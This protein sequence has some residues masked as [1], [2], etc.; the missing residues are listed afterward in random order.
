MIDFFLFFLFFCD[1]YNL[2]ITFLL[3]SIFSSAWKLIFNTE[4][5][6]FNI[7][8]I[9]IYCFRFRWLIN[10]HSFIFL[11]FYVHLL[12]SKQFLAHMCETHLITQWII[13]V[14]IQNTIETHSNMLISNFYLTLF[15]LC[16]C[17]M[18]IFLFTYL[19]LLVH[20]SIRA[21]KA[22]SCSLI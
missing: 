21:L 11:I 9:L 13:K 16:C 3:L 17:F 14:T 5:S 15:L 6:S 18:Y 8:S 7:L 12:L 22:I 10:F 1:S 4:I 19:P 2:L 20:A